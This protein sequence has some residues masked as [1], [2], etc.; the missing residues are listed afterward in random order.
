VTLRCLL[1][2]VALTSAPA[3]AQ[4]V[5]GELYSGDASVRGSVQLSAQGIQVE[6]GSQ[7]SAGEASA[8]LRLRRGGEITVCPRTRLSLNQAGNHSLVLGLNAGAVELD[9]QLTSGADSLLTPDFR[10]QLISPASFRVAVS[11]TANGDTCMAT[12]PGDDASVFVTEMMGSDSYQLSPG[13]SVLFRG[14]KIA[15]ATAA[16]ARCGCPPV[17]QP[18]TQPAA[19]P[20]AP[21]PDALPSAPAHVPPAAAPPRPARLPGLFTSSGA[22]PEP[23]H[24]EAIPTFN[25][26]GDRPHDEFS[27]VVLHLRMVHGG[28]RLALLLLPQPLPPGAG[29]PAEKK[30]GLLR[31][32]SGFFDRIFRR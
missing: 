8:R 24:L 21:A 23:D 19:Q 9:Y 28:R 18:V 31:R 29:A 26:R 30:P 16:P 12:L 14:G 10:L 5:V 2:A 25:L 32:V 6:S 11:V 17:A 20:A 1:L 3:F 7:L 15:A 27:N 13:K 4:E 22:K